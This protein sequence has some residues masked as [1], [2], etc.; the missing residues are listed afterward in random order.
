[1]CMKLAGWFGWIDGAPTNYSLNLTAPLPP[2]QTAAAARK[3]A[4]ERA[5]GAMLAARAVAALERRGS[6]EQCIFRR[7]NWDP[8]GLKTIC[9]QPKWSQSVI[10]H[11]E[12]MF[13]FLETRMK[14][15]WVCKAA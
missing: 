8:S 7:L 10:I 12:H 11:D 6:N 14:S 15:L 1:M 13:V 3:A 4:M 5:A 9:S 2:S